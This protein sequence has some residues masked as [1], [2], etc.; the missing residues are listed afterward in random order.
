MAVKKTVKKAAKA[1]KPAAKKAPAKKAPA[2]KAEE[3]GEDEGDTYALSP[4]VKGQL[5]AIAA[6]VGDHDEFM[7]AAF[8]EVTLDDDGETAVADEEFYL[9]LK[10]G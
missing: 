5:R 10:A 2:K 9:S 1:A 3:A 7:E 6:R 8:A 4:K